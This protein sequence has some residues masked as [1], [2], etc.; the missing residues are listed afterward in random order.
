MN[1]PEGPY[2]QL[3]SAM[4]TQHI[5]DYYNSAKRMV[6]LS[7]L[8]L[9]GSGGREH[10]YLCAEFSDNKWR[11]LQSKEFLLSPWFEELSNLNGEEIKRKLDVKVSAYGN[12]RI[13]RTTNKAVSKN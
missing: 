8:Y 4:V 2:K 13:L 5:R 7:I 11:Y 9:T 10:A 1:Y 12:E 3:A 6:T